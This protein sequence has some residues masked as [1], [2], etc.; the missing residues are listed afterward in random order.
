MHYRIVA[1]RIDASLRGTPLDAVAGRCD[2]QDGLPWFRIVSHGSSGAPP[3]I[4]VRHPSSSPGQRHKQGSGQAPVI[5]VGSQGAGRIVA[6][7]GDEGARSIGLS[8]DM[9][10]PGLALGDCWRCVV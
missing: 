8:M 3:G 4:A 5:R 1:T 7:P 9:G 10:S 6:G 2:A